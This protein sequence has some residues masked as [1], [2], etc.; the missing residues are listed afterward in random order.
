MAI[1][2]RTDQL[3]AILSGDVDNNDLM[4]LVHENAQAETGYDSKKI[5]VSD[6]GRKL[7]NGVEYVSELSSFPSGHQNPLDA[8]E[9]LKQEILDLYPVNSA[10][11][12]IANFT[13]S[14]A[15]PLVDIDVDFSAT[16]VYQEG[17]NLKFSIIENCYIDNT[18]KIVSSQSYYMALAKVKSGVTYTTNT[19]TLI[20]GFFTSIPEL[21]SVSYN[22]TRLL[23]NST[24]FVAPIDGYIAFRCDSPF[25]DSQIEVG[26]NS[27][28][29]EPYNPNSNI[30]DISELDDI[31]AFAGVNNIWADSGD[32]EMSFKQGIQEYI[33]SKIAETQA[34]IL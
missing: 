29:Y 18:G 8:L 24:T 10:S 26:S 25:T 4:Y 33:D 32:I 27:T 20:C 15:L 14:L 2:K 21:G 11:G 9:L 7:N 34:L 17:K 31:V 28:T 6:V 19:P 3:P 13:T 22:G 16:K 23:Q 12:S 1:K 30:Y 5:L